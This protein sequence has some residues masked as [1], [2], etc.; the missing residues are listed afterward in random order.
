[1]KRV[2]AAIDSPEINDKKLSLVEED[3]NYWCVEEKGIGWLVELKENAS[4]KTTG[5][6]DLNAINSL[7]KCL[8]I[9]YDRRMDE[10]KKQIIN[11]P[12]NSGRRSEDKGP[13]PE[14]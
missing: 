4:S 3:G 12:V 7:S 9:Q 11:T 14:W 13:L 1:M 2:V 8:S 6:A 10:Q 5:R